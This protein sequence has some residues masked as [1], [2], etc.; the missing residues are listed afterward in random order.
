M[1]KLHDSPCNTLCLCTGSLGSNVHN[2]IP[3]MIRHF[4]EMD[5][6]GCLHVRTSSIWAATAVSAR[7]ATCPP[8]AIWIC[9]RS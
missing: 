4:G 2:D 3:A 1:V 6:I 9:T 5:R 7:A 8:T